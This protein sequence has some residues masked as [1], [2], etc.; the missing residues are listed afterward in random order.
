MPFRVEIACR[1]TEKDQLQGLA[2]PP[3]DSFDVKIADAV[4]ATSAATETETAEM[5]RSRIED[6]LQDSDSDFAVTLGTAT[7]Y[8]I[9]KNDDFTILLSRNQSFAEFLGLP[10]SD[11]VEVTSVAGGQAPSIFESERSAT[12]STGWRFHLRKTGVSHG[13]ARSVKLLKQQVYKVTIQIKRGE[14]KQWRETAR[15]MLL[16]LPF[17]LYTEKDA[18]STNGYKM[19]GYTAGNLGGKIY[20][21]LDAADSQLSESQLTTPYQSDVQISF[22]AVAVSTTGGALSV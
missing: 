9:S 7:N 21:Q 14:I 12:V 6:H 22:N 10:T 5:L 13:Q 11:Q 17:T 19:T 8:T 15:Y 20:M 16:G 18:S 3:G 1:F 2:N 4:G